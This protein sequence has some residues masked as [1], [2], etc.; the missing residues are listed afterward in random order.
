MY[1]RISTQAE[2]ANETRQIDGR[3]GH[4]TTDGSLTVRVKT[5]G[6]CALR[7]TVEDQI[8]HEPEQRTSA[9][10]LPKNSDHLPLKEQIDRD[11]TH[12]LRLEQAQH[13][14]L[15]WF[16]DHHLTAKN[17]QMTTNTTHPRSLLVSVR[18]SAVETRLH[19][20]LSCWF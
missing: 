19:R 6:A 3:Y 1:E 7:N 18:L 9:V 5:P 10:A 12:D 17:Q 20:S 2:M 8:L 13:S 14:H 15:V 11:D 4:A 16:V